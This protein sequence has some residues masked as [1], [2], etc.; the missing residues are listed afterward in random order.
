[1]PP[2]S[3]LDPQR[4]AKHLGVSYSTVLSWARSGTIPAIRDKR[5]RYLFHVNAVFD[6]LLASQP[7]MSDGPPAR[8][9][10]RTRPTNGFGSTK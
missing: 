3:F 10:E 7:E 1:M 4:L 9:T 6:A 5:G 8:N 2:P